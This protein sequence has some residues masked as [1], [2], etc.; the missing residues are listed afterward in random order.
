MQTLISQCLDSN[1]LS[2]IFSE[3]GAFYHHNVYTTQRNFVTTLLCSD[4][5][6]VTNIEKVDSVTLLRKDKLLTSEISWTTRFQH[7]LAVWPCLNNLG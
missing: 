6:F 5:Y 3:A 2:E 1:F 4:D 7:A